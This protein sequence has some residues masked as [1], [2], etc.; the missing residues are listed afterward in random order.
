MPI[1]LGTIYCTKL[2]C[3]GP[4]LLRSWSCVQRFPSALDPLTKNLTGEQFAT[5]TKRNQAVT[6][7]LQK[8]HNDF[9]YSRVIALVPHW[10]IHLKTDS[11]YVGSV[12][13]TLCYTCAVV[14]CFCIIIER[15]NLLLRAS[16]RCSPVKV[17][18]CI[19][20]MRQMKIEIND[21]YSARLWN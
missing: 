14:K 3:Y 4:P 19:F 17:A 8:L 5:D 15:H 11:A 10:K 20:V 12:V 6:C 9:F 1:R 7:V 2:R 16:K 18:Y 13:C 21:K